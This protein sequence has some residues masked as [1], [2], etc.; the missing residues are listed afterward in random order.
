MPPSPVR[1]HVK[2]LRDEK[3]QRRDEQHDQEQQQHARDRPT[4]H[5]LPQFLD[6]D[7]IQLPLAPVGEV[8]F[9]FGEG[10]GHGERLKNIQQS[11]SNIE[12]P[13]SAGRSR[14]WILGWMFD[15]GVSVVFIARLLW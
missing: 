15:V 5:A 8:G 1:V 13:N 4:A 10:G 6:D 9:E 7:G 3:T 14:H 11:T 2:T 12:H